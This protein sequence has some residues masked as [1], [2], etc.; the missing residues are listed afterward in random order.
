MVL[1]I[2]KKYKMHGIKG[3]VFALQVTIWIFE[4]SGT[5]ISCPEICF[6]PLKLIDF[7]CS[8]KLRVVLFIFMN[9][10]VGR[11]CRYVPFW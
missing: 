11:V 1:K 8:M 9:E 4:F 6:V 10:F 2:A 7:L 5:V 3:R